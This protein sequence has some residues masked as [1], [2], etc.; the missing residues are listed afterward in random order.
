MHRV[1][2]II[3]RNSY[4]YLNKNVCN[5]YYVFHSSLSA[6]ENYAYLHLN[7]ESPANILTPSR[8]DID[9]D[10][11]Y[12]YYIEKV[13]IKRLVYQSHYKCVSTEHRSQKSRRGPYLSTYEYF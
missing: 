9:V 12:I 10:F 11:A 6:L 3:N 5:D 2:I 4:E 13:F 1:S 7:K 8:E